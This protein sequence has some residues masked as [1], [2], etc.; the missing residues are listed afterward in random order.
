M[1][2]FCLAA[3]KAL[4]KSRRPSPKS[5]MKD[6]SLIVMGNG[7]ALRDAID[8]HPEWLKANHLLAVNFAANTSEFFSLKPELYVLADP[9]FFNLPSSDPNV[10]KLWKNIAR[11]D[12]K[13]SLWIPISMRNR[14]SSLSLPSC[15]TP[16]FFNLTPG[17]GKGTLLWRLYD[18]G[19]AMPRPRNVLIPSIMIGIREGYKKIYLA[20]ADHTWTRTL[21][22]NDDNRVVSIQPHFYKDSDGELKRV[23][24]EYKGLHLHDVLG[25]MTIAFRSYFEIADYA[26]SRGVQILNAT[27]GSFIDAFPRCHPSL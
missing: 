25:S 16:K 12:W 11:S 2:N 4:L 27:P 19:L 26:K 15:I 14:L 13:M 20:G 17:D 24:T 5:D 22:V 6:S 8:N 1:L 18:K 9:H 3:A 23:E 10:E 7:P 21:S